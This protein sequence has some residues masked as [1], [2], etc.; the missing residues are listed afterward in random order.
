MKTL[1]AAVLISAAKGRTCEEAR[2]ALRKASDDLAR[3]QQHAQVQHQRAP[4]SEATRA[5]FES[6]QEA[7]RRLNEAQQDAGRCETVK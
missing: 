5:A 6:L 7:S 2:E 1:L 3:A 4:D